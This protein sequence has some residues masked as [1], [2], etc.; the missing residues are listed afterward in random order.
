MIIQTKNHSPRWTPVPA[1]EQTENQSYIAMKEPVI[2]TDSDSKRVRTES[3]MF[4]YE[5]TENRQVEFYVLHFIL[6]QVP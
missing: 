5:R 3:E 6:M 1:F 4:A 2:T